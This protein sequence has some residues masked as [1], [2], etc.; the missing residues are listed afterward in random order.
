MRVAKERL[1]ARRFF[2]VVPPIERLAAARH[3]AAITTDFDDEGI[4]SNLALA[5]EHGVV[6]ER[7]RAGAFTVELCFVC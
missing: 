6:E 7:A 4:I 1:H 3:R 2:D 5:P